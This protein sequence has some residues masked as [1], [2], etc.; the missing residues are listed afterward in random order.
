MFFFSPKEIIPLFE[1]P[2]EKMRITRGHLLMQFCLKLKE[3]YDYRI[4]HLDKNN[5]SAYPARQFQKTPIRNK[6]F[7]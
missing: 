7:V 5:R 4:R 6:C 1:L 3:I 2:D